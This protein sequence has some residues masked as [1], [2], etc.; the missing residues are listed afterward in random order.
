MEGEEE[1]GEMRLMTKWKQLDTGGECKLAE[2]TG[3]KGK[4]Y[5]KENRNRMC[6][7]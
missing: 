3:S 2:L 1:G 6:E 5:K 7:R 4:N